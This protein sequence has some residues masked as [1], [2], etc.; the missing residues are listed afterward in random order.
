MGP[1]RKKK[2]KN[3][4]RRVALKKRQWGRGDYCYGAGL[5]SD[6]GKTKRARRPIAMFE[7]KDYV[8][9]THKK[10]GGQELIEKVKKAPIRAGIGQ[11]RR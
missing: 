8:G 2:K 10:R 6:R 9:K 3:K 7:N 4:K 11:A 1:K 5:P